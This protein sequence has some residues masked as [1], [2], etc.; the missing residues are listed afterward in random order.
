MFLKPD[1]LNFQVLKKLWRSFEKAIISIIHQNCWRRIF[2]SALLSAFTS[3]FFVLR[4]ILRKYVGLPKITHF[5]IGLGD[6]SKAS[7]ISSMQLFCNFIARIFHIS[8]DSEHCAIRWFSLL[9]LY[10]WFSYSLRNVHS[11][12]NEWLH[13]LTQKASGQKSWAMLE[14]SPFTCSDY[15]INSII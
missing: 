2:L 7:L 5:H 15:E 11:R 12:E 9:S 14:L 6:Y 3:R 4:F 1:S 10:L 13:W 8:L